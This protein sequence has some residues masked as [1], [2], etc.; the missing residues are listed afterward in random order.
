MSGPMLYN[1]QDG[2]VRSFWHYTTGNGD[3]S[4]VPDGQ[5]R[6]EHGGHPKRDCAADGD[7]FQEAPFIRCREPMLYDA[8]DGNAPVVFGIT[9][10]AT[11]IQTYLMD[12]IDPNTGAILSETVL[13][14]ET[15][16]G[17]PF[18]PMSGP[19]LYDAQ[20]GNVRSFWHYTTGNGNPT[21]Y[22]MD[23]IRSEHG[24]HPKRDCAANGNVFRKPLLSDVGTDALRR[25]GWLCP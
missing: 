8:Q 21:T 2:N 13:P 24:G 19:M 14:T 10:R 3:Q 5:D 17:S 15:F 4:S 25:A 11:V 18:Y 6:S 1:A 20:D 9:P 7:V 22:L 16:S 23:K 12:K